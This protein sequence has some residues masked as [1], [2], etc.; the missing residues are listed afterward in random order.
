M[1]ENKKFILDEGGKSLDDLLYPGTNGVTETVRENPGK[2]LLAGAAA[3][4]LAA[5]AI[6][7]ATK[8]GNDK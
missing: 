6:S 3:V 1:K 7:K 2:A 4:G 5:V 8:K